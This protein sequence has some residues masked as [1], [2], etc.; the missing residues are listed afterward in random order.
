MKKVNNATKLYTVLTIILG[1]IALILLIVGVATRKWIRITIN[2]S[3]LETQINQA[4][5]DTTFITS[6]VIATN[7][8]Q[9]QVVQIV[10]A[11]AQKVE[12]QLNSIASSDT[13]YHLYGKNPN[14]PPTSPK[15]KSPQGFIFAGLS[16][17]FVG[18]LLALIVIIFGLP[19]IIRYLPLFFLSIGPIF[20]T[21]GFSI[22]PK[23]IIE[24]FGKAIELSIHVG[25]SIFL[26]ISAALVGFNAASTFAFIVLQPLLNP[27]PNTR[28][29]NPA[30]RSIFRHSYPP[31]RMRRRW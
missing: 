6:L 13:T 28:V 15:F 14:V 11:A 29:L 27:P 7:A 4:L 31:T 3:P 22:Y 1:I 25:F 5:T 10:S 30:P 21:I 19:R 8:S 17:V 26:V 18:L 9:T 20:I 23:L 2:L 16:S 12:Q 24:D